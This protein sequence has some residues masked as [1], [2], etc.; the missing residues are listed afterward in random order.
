[1]PGG[2]STGRGTEVNTQGPGSVRCR[3]RSEGVGNP[4]TLESRAWEL[5][6]PP[7]REAGG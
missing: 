1:M 2:N 4:L 5:K 3:M 7:G 6:D